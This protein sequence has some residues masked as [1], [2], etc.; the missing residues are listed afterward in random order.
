MY[1]KIKIYCFYESCE[2]IEIKTY[3]KRKINSYMIPSVFI[4]IE[5][6]KMNSNHKI[7]RKHLYEII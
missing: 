5:K 3:L 4:R 2:E 6:F 1:L 7:D